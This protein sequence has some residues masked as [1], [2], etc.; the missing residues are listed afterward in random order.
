RVAAV[1]AFLL[2]AGLLAA[3]TVSTLNVPGRP[4]SERWGL[5]D[6]RD[7]AYYPVVALRHGDNPYDAATYTRRYPVRNAF[8]PYAPLMLALHAPLVML[9]LERAELVY[10][11]IT[12]SLA[13]PL[14]GLALAA[15][16]ARQDATVFAVV[17]AAVLLSRPGHWN[18][19]LG[20]SAILLVVAT[21]GA[22]HW[23]RARPGLSG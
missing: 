8:P 9:S 23:L 1:A 16:G 21:F 15:C 4:D 5:A 20:Q 13:L 3:R 22:L 19:L 6:F 12:V 14:V 17:A 10:W 18:V 7:N 11:L 2:A